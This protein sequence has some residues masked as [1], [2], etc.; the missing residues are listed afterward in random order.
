MERRL[1]ELREKLAEVE[2]LGRAAR[3]LGWDQQTMMPPAG[4]PARAEQLATLDRIAHERF[5][6][7]EIGRLLEELRPYEESLDPASVDASLVRV[8][9]RDY[10]KAVR[11][12]P[13]LSADI[14]RSASLAQQAWIEARAASDFERFRPH[15][16]RNLELK[17]RYV[18][19]F[20]PSGE[21]YDVL[22]DD[23]E[24]GTTTVEVR[25][26]FARIKERLVPLI[27]A[28]GESGRPVD[29]G[30]LR[31]AFPVE[32]QHEFERSVLARFGYDEESWR[33]DPAAHPFA[34]NFSSR[35]IRLT[36]RHY[37]DNLTGLFASMHECGHGLYEFGS[38][39]ELDR[40]PL[41]GGVSLGLH[42]SQ[43]RLWENLVGRSRA[44]WR[45]FYPDLQALFPDELRPEDGE[46]FYRAVNCVRPSLIRVD[47]D[48]VTYGLHVILRF[49]LE[50]ELVD[51]RLALADLP[52][53]WNERMLQYLGVEVPSDA[54]GVLQ[55]IHWSGGIFGYF[56]T[57][58]LGSVMSVQ[59]W[60]AAGQ[61]IPDL[62]GQIEAGEF[63]ALR[64][65]L[66]E[67]LHRYGRMF[68]PKETL[69]R[70]VGGP[71]D[72]EPYLTYLERKVEDVYGLAV[73]AA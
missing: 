61:A 23:F 25:E 19:C 7:P 9:R 54:D 53:A 27:A 31:G 3:V 16:E 47:A 42:E 28:V 59:I 64:E 56:P 38:D 18:E 52:D 60:E 8:T 21:R 2:D 58:L 30:L 26:L 51:G 13:E 15:L 37:D 4:A 22:L 71:I 1:Q 49:E 70:V 45:R 35:D 67:N 46:E 34:T 66:R 32:R 41:A 62:E 33:M 39:S 17:N 57:Y 20:E 48:E 44:F 50:Q 14:A 63:D 29:T 55:D 36:T 11:V 69:A 43:S 68:T 5:T 40:T 6:S 24:H 72:P 12:P 65:W 73:P 10:E